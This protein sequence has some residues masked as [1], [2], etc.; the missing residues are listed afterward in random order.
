MKVMRLIEREKQQLIYK[1]S[2]HIDQEFE[3]VR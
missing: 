2:M 3:L 1:A